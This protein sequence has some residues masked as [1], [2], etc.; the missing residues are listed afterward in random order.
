MKTPLFQM[1]Q[2]LGD[3]SVATMWP[4][5]LRDRSMISGPSRIEDE[6]Q[7]LVILTYDGEIRLQ[8]GDWL[9]CAGSKIYRMN[10]EYSGP[11]SSDNAD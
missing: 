8:P 7:T 11:K 2:W 3:P 1:W 4:A 10:P 9:V 6:T 5:W